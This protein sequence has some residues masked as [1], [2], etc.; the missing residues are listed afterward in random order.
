MINLRCKNL[1][2][3]MSLMGLYLP[4]S[5]V[6]VTSA[7]PLIAT[8]SRTSNNVCDGQKRTPALQQT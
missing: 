1:E 4:K 5:D 7:F 2:L 6:R 3:H 8:K